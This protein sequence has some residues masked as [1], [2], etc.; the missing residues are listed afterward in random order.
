MSGRH[1]S[2]K[3]A[4]PARLASTQSDRARP[5]AGHWRAVRGLCVLGAALSGVVAL[6]AGE[7]HDLG[8]LLE[9]PGARTGRANGLAALG[10]TGAIAFA[11]ATML[12]APGWSTAM[13]GAIGGG[14]AFATGG[15]WLLPGAILIAASIW[16][17]VLLP[18]PFADERAGEVRAGADL[19]VKGSRS[20]GRREH[21][22]GTFA[23]RSAGAPQDHRLRTRRY[24]KG[25]NA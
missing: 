21:E 25:R 15:L 5:P 3:T 24:R 14:G 13:I 4:D 8:G 16:S 10:L 7:V 18:D 19:P 20:G 9:L 1:P 12:R 23:A 2:G 11:A 6:R 22:P 17:V